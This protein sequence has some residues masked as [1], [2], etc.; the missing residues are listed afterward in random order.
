LYNGE[1][2]WIFFRWFGSVESREQYVPNVFVSGIFEIILKG[3]LVGKIESKKNIDS[4][5]WKRLSWNWIGYLTV[6]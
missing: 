6:F 1:R 3:N 5:N 2:E 4:K